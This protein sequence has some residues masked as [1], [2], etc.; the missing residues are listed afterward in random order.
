MNESAKV[1]SIE[2]LESFCTK[3]ALLG[4]EARQALDD[5]SIEIN[6]MKVWLQADQRLF[7]EGRLRERLRKLEE[8]RSAGRHKVVSV[9]SARM[10]ARSAEEKAKRAVAEAEEKLRLV[11][12]W[13]ARFD[14]QVAPIAGAVARLR[15]SLA[16]DVPKAVQ[17]LRHTSEILKDYAESGR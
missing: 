8:V 5:V 3:L 9:P 11:K 13:N 7:W 15:D 10:A 12:Q 16:M 2:A 6:R 14:T 4:N 1:K 17:H